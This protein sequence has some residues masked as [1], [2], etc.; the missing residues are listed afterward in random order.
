M[1][2]SRPSVEIGICLFPSTSVEETVALAR[3]CE[4][5]GFGFVGIG[6]VQ[7]LWRDLYVTAALV[8]ARTTRLRI[9]PWVTN[10]VTRDPAVT[11]NAILTLQEV[12]GGRVFLGIGVGDGAVARLGRRP[13][14]LDDLA[15][16]VGEIRRHVHA[17]GEPIKIYWA[18]AGPRSLAYAAEKSDGII[19]SGWIAPEVMARTHAAIAAGLARGGR[20]PDDIELIFNTAVCVGRSRAAAIEAAKPYVARALA[21]SSSAWLPDWS[22]HDVETFKARYDYARHFQDDH[23]L[24]KLVPDHMVPR[25]AV[26][27]S[28]DE[29][30]EL[31]SRIRE[32]GFRKIALIPVGHAR[33]VLQLLA[34]DILPRL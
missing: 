13:A 8:A 11:A 9:G 27:G 16:A 29:C 22:E 2:L 24:K 19:V 12:S 21:R 7:T 32:S 15:H 1:G 10:P 30:L 3:Q 34:T 4:D 17:A 31:L 26:A 6:D 25:K 18:A 14:T 5:L 20:R 33:E 28:P 23:E